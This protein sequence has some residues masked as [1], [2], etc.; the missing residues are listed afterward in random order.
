MSQNQLYGCFVRLFLVNNIEF[1]NKIQKCLCCLCEHTK[2]MLSSE[3]HISYM[4][5]NPDNMYLI[6]KTMKTKFFLSVIQ[7]VVA[8]LG[9]LTEVIILSSS[10]KYDSSEEHLGTGIWCGLLFGLSGSL[11]I[12]ASLK[13]KEAWTTAI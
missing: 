11:G 8:F 6:N 5:N 9:I 3:K 2:Y 10:D 1:I 12:V 7:C 4:I 13:Q